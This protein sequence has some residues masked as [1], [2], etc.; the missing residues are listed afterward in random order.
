MIHRILWATDGSSDAAESLRYV[1]ILACN[2]KAE[3]LG[4]YILPDYKGMIENFSV[5][6][7]TKFAKW[8]DEILK[9]KEKKKLEAIRKDFGAK[10]IS[11]NIAIGRGIPHKEI[12]R[13]ATE[14]KVGLIALGKGRA[15]ERAILGG[16]ALKVIRDSK[17]PVLTVR[18]DTRRADIKRI[19]AP[20][21]QSHGLSKGFKY[22]VEISEPFGAIINML[23]VVEIGEHKI[24]PEI[25]ERMKAFC[26]RE[27]KEN[28]GKVKMS[29]NI[30]AYVEA[31]KNAWKGI[32]K[33]AD[34]RDID[35]IVMM[36]YGGAKFKE[37]FI[38]SVT[39]K[40]IQEAHCPV[41]TI[42][43]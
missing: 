1:E 9:A 26:F 18:E 15:V 43:P 24:P 11:F 10:G 25:V 34:D 7:K 37:E 13:V 35:L 17:I 14:K 23:N 19:L 28:V 16:T 5:E 8:I 30:E 32:V 21:D 41:I 31:A 20:I 2:F 38:G 6:E 12:M 3:I 27:L 29:K 39:Q 22:A 33:F 36:T 42:K 40:V 4:L